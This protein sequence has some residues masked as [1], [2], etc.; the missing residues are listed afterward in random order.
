MFN[1]HVVMV[2]E[3]KREE[4]ESRPKDFLCGKRFEW[5]E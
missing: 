4:S 5:W 2:M 1:V 3:R